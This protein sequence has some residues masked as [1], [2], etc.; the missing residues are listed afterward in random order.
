VN[1]VFDR[2]IYF[3]EIPNINTILN[4]RRYQNSDQLM[5][6]PPRPNAMKLLTFLITPYKYTLY[7]DGDVSPCVGFQKFIFE[8]LLLNDILSTPNTFGYESTNG[9]KTYLAS[10]KHPKF[11]LFPE[12]NGGVFAYVWS[13]KTRDLFIR[14]IE[15]IPH[16]ASIGYDQVSSNI[17]IYLTIYL[18]IYLSIYL[19]KYLSR[20]KL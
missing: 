17:S 19:T 2:V 15:L 9:E 3:D 10:P 13:N 4:T 12:I 20:I 18:S 7:L 5:R 16:F 1:C 6:L 14:A 11:P 8:N